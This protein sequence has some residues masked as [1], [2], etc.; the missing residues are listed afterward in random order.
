MAFFESFA[1]KFVDWVEEFGVDFV[2]FWQDLAAK[3]AEY[4]AEFGAAFVDF[5]EAFAAKFVGLFE[6]FEAPALSFWEALS[7]GI[8]DLLTALPAMLEAIPLDPVAGYVGVITGGALIGLLQWLVV[9]RHVRG[10]VGW[11]LASAGALAVV[12]VVIFG[13][14]VV[15]PDLGWIAGVSLFGTVVGVLQWTVLRQQIPRAG[16][17]VLASTVGWVLGMPAGDVN[18][19]PALGAVYGAVTATVLVWLLRQRRSDDGS[20]I[21]PDVQVRGGAT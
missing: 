6:G 9:R 20:T 1:V 8:Y 7:K 11:V 17:W 5:W 3:L 14:G 2:V 13:V 18:G 10:A 21:E 4:W 15:D 12:G 19:P 16:W